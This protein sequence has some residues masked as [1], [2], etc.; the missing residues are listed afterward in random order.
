LVAPRGRESIANRDTALLSVL[1]ALEARSTRQR[2]SIRS[3]THDG[4][5]NVDP[6]I[7]TSRPT[8]TPA[9]DKL[10]SAWRLS[11]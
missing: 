4:T 10:F 5:G 6:T 1:D 7:C 2:D 11:L 9:L 8:P 3:L